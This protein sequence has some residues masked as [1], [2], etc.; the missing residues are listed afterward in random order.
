MM[1]AFVALAKHANVTRAAESL[2]ITQQGLS[3]QLAKLR[4]LTGDELLVRA[5]KGMR[6]TPKA[7]ELLPKVEEVLNGIEQ[8][9]HDE[10]FI[11]SA[12]EG[13]VVI[14]ATDY[15]I[16]LLAPNL[17]RTLNKQAPNLQIR[18]RHIE[19]YKENQSLNS[20]EADLILSVPEFSSDTSRAEFLFD[21]TYLGFARPG[22]PIFG[23][24]AVDLDL[25]CS[26]E[27]LLVSPFRG[28]AFGAT[29]RAL[30][31]L[32][33]KRRIAITVPDFSIVE[34]ILQKSDLIS[35]LP[36]RLA[37]NMSGRL[38]SFTVPVELEPFKL[39]AYWPAYLQR[40]P[41]NL[42]LRTIVKE[43]AELIQSQ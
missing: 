18:V 33:L 28:D 11:P 43:C 39:Y 21:E 41:L 30:E 16:A 27:H 25:F 8:L 42:W 40:D 19:D 24:E 31:K 34:T 29:D 15:A 32:G 5:D 3:G 38:Q 20:D 17:I 22:H 36:K 13:R 4:D 35:V 37:E 12:V 1:L 26:Y 6:L 23:P 7:L 9:M 14:A 10:E 2:N